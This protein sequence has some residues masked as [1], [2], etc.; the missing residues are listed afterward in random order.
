[1]RSMIVFLSIPSEV[2]FVV[3]GGVAGGLVV[4]GIVERGGSV[5]GG[6]TPVTLTVSEYRTEVLIIPSSMIGNTIT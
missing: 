1:M 3:A 5:G 6:E 4:C 2:V